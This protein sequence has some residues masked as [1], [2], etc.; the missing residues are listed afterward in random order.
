VKL[1]LHVFNDGRCIL[2]TDDLL[3]REQYQTIKHCWDEWVLSEVAHPVLII[4]GAVEVYD[5][6]IGDSALTI[7]PSP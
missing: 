6:T 2:S 7:E 4:S 3:T 5:V 1:K